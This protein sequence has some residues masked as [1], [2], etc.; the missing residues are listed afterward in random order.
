VIHEDHDGEEGKVLEAVRVGSPDPAEHRRFVVVPHLGEG[1]R[2]GAARVDQDTPVRQ[3]DNDVQQ[4]E[5][6]EGKECGQRRSGFDQHG[7]DF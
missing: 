2:L 6:T 5:A 7:D 3:H 4:R 1:R